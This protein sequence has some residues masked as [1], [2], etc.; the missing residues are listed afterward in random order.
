MKIFFRI[1]LLITL[2]FG[3]AFLSWGQ[4][5]NYC[6]LPS[7]LV[8]QIPPNV[9]FLI[10]KSYSMTYCAYTSNEGACPVAAPAPEAYDSSKTYEGYF[11]PDEYY[12]LNASGVYEVDPTPGTCQT[13]C[14]D[15]DCFNSRFGTQCDTV[16]GT[17]SCNTNK[18]ACC[19][20]YG[21]TGA[22]T[23]LSGNYLNYEHMKR[24]DI[25]RWALTGGKLSSC[26]NETDTK[27]NADE[28]IDPPHQLDCDS[29]GCIL[30]AWDGTKV[31]APW[32]R[33]NGVNPATGLIYTNPELGM[34]PKTGDYYALAPGLLFQLKTELDTKPYVGAMF[35][36]GTG[37]V[38]TRYLV[39]W[40][41]SAKT[42]R[43]LKAP[44][45]ACTW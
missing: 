12:V 10:D 1:I 27:C 8:T 23:V 5:A 31:K 40:D 2:L 6:Q 29:Y 7:S 19:M 17:H 3:G 44:G 16:K 4:M 13:V 18:Y 28:Y 20:S 22:C 32:R 35:F 14:N 15:W 24:I 21:Q 36:N 43:F 33:I 37:A 42:G 30:T 11:I 41:Y 38:H 9:L 26:T 39:W 45:M 25:L 34:N